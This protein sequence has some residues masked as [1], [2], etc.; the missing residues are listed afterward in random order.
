MVR[1]TILIELSYGLTVK[2]ISDKHKIKRKTI[3]Y[4]IDMMKKENGCRNTTHL[5]ATCLRL[6]IIK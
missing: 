2:N 6:K 3:E 4:H 1:E 5:V